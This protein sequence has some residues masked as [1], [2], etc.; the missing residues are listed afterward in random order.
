VK[1]VVVSGIP[2]Y[3]GSYQLFTT[4]E[5][6]RREWGWMKRLAEY[7]P[8]DFMNE[9]QRGLGDPEFLSV[10]LIVALHRAGKIGTAE[11][12]QVWERLADFNMFECLVIHTDEVVEEEE[13]LPPT[14]ETSSNGSPVTSGLVSP[15]SSVI[16][17]SSPS[18]PGSPLSATSESDPATSGR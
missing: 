14:S 7:L 9:E 17:D 10:V 11:V 4:D 12:P 1:S 15:T 18:A 3:D 5:F 8:V 13:Q 2:P 16:S 6:N